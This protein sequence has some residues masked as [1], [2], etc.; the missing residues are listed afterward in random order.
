MSSKQLRVG[1]TVN[2][3]SIIGQEVT[4]SGHVIREILKTTSGNMVAFI[5]GISGYVS[6]KALSKD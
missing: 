4:S 5:T 2:Y 3:R 1:D 6:L